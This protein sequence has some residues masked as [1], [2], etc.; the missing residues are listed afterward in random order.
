MS[1][2]T[3]V[4]FEVVDFAENP[5]PRCPC[6]LLLDVSTSMNGRAIQELNDGLAS[7]R[8]ELVSDSL[9]M[10]RVDV[11]IV[12]FGPAQVHTPFTTAGAFIAPTLHANGDTPIGE[13]IRLGLNML[14]QRKAEYRNAGIVHYRPWVFMITDGAPT[15][16]WMTAAAAIR[17]SEASKKLAF[18]AVG[19]AGARM[20]IL[21]QIS[22]RQPLKL[23][24]MKFRELFQWL[25][26]SMKSVSQSTPGAEV[27]LIAPSGWAAV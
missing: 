16:E 15:D 13:A 19:V 12:T 4:F 5:E 14:E 26:A 17:E 8:E 2:P 10:Q 23:D 18:F 20:D 22:V 9:A 25:S 3:Q 6:L 24:G 11:G 7:F 27:A 21:S 1:E